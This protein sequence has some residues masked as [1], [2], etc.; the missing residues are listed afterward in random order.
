[1]DCGIIVSWTETAFDAFM[2]LSGDQRSE[3]EN[4]ITCSMG[5]P[6]FVLPGLRCIGVPGW[7]ERAM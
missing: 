3:P 6:S 5:V 1:M 2:Q 4:G 7:A